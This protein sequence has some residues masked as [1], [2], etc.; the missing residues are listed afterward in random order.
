MLIRRPSA[1]TSTVQE[2][3]APS[4]SVSPDGRTARRL[5]PAAGGVVIGQRDDVETGLRGPGDDR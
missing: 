1:G 2:S 3:S 4:T 5:R